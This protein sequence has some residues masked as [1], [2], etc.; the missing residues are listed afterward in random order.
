MR[1]ILG[2][3]F[4]RWV[5]A[6]LGFLCFALLVWFIGPLVAIAEYRPLGPAW[7]RLALIF[8]VVFAYLFTVTLE[9][10]RAR[11]AS[12][13]LEAGMLAPAQTV[14]PGT[15]AATEHTQ[16]QQ[17]FSEALQVL[18][19][20]RSKSA[21]KGWRG[22]MAGLD[23]SRYL[24]ELPWYVIVGAPGTGK[25][26]ALVNS[27]LHFPLAERFGSESVQG[28][29]GTRNC[30]WLFTD[31][32]VL[33]DTAGRYSTQASDKQADSKEWASFLQ[34]LA[35]NRPRQPINGVMVT[36]SATDLI[37]ATTTELD[38][39]ANALRNRIQ[40]LHKELKISFPIYLLVT[41]SDVLSGFAEFFDEMTA[42][43]RA[44][45][46]GVSFP[47]AKEGA[48]P[49]GMHTVFPVEFDSLLDR[50][51]QRVLDLLEKERD[52]ERRS[53]LYSFPQN[54][55][56]MGG[57]LTEFLRLVFAP[58]P[59]EQP[60]MLRGVY[61]T[62]G[63]QDGAQ[64]DPLF[65]QF[66]RPL[67]LDRP[68]PVQRKA[69]GRSYF[70]SRLLT[71]VIFAESQLA[72][73]NRRWLRRRNLI[74]GGGYAAFALV[75]VG[76][77]AGWTVSYLRNDG[78]LLDV[79]KQLPAARKKVDGVVTTRAEQLSD[80]LPA[81]EVVRDVASTQEVKQDKAPY[82]M[83]LG[84]YQGDKLHSAADNAYKRLLHEALL[85]RIAFRL[86]EALRNAGDDPE[87]RYEALKAYLMIHDADHFDATAF[88]T[89]VLVDWEARLSRDVTS[90]QRAELALHLD[91]LLANK[92]VTSPVPL[93]EKLVAEAREALL[94]R[95]LA[96]RV[97]GR[98]KRMGIAREVPDFKATEIA[99]PQAMVVLTRTS[100]EPLSKGVSGFYSLRGYYQHFMKEINGVAREMAEEQSWV[101]GVKQQAPASVPAGTTV[102][103]EFD[104]AALKKLN[105]DVRK[106]YL[107]EYANTWEKYVGDIKLV[108][109]GNLQQSVNAARVLS[110]PDS[111]LAALLRGIVKETSLTQIAEADKTVVDKASDT[112]NQKKEA[113]K[114]MIGQG[115]QLTP[116]DTASYRLE[117]IVDDRFEGLRRLVRS[118]QAGQ[119]APLDASLGL[120]NEFYTYLTATDTAVKSGVPAPQSDLPTRLKAESARMPEPMRSV[121]QSLSTA[122]VSQALG[123]T[124]DNLSSSMS[125]AVADF[126][127][128]A[129]G[130]RYPFN[131]HASS[132]VRQDDFARLFATGGVLDEFFQKNLAQ[133]VDTGKKPWQFRQV[134]EGSMGNASGALIQFQR[135]A[136]IRDVF[137]QGGARTP[138]L[139]LDFK[140]V[141]M[142]A[143]LIQ[144]V[145]DIDGQVIK[146]AHGPQVPTTISWPGP[147]GSGQVRVQF[148]GQGGAEAGGM[149]F[150]GAW[151]LF[152]ALDKAQIVSTNQPEKFR[153]IFDINGKKAQYEVT[154]GSVQNPF[155][156]SELAQ[157][158]CPSRL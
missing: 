131:R 56:E 51:N 80:L 107:E 29:G 94:R 20:A 93:D 118:P 6:A 103:T 78:Y 89:W 130:G 25:T 8:G 5:L 14:E 43:E 133:Y 63:T 48:E 95:T 76:A 10:W 154:S 111:P 122:G 46:W 104:P 90:Q 74:M 136:V 49:V 139:K 23:S 115:D 18:K 11:R 26:T 30:N 47:L 12:K 79:E 143:S 35:K 13:S 148:V 92:S 4:N 127:S 86:E 137:F 128:K 58:S 50:L 60:V 152:R 98:L 1:S 66:A 145:I 64:V 16:L 113:L 39:Q 132:D 32:A 96:E 27:G 15:A 146:Y 17:R 44:Q 62:S 41:K 69:S 70:I 59:Y 61:F 116:A 156:L 75:S 67:A 57:P 87:L 83:R 99:G 126:C 155:R 135:A 54:F 119:P 19:L 157:F 81:L 153:V 82:S 120:L 2:L 52:A 38:L 147:K 68:A 125:S 134:G 40:E 124:R 114:R 36:I 129:V 100:G 117:R 142:D 149:V 109:F 144:S 37:H 3:I 97:Y 138:T 108:Q 53:R 110:A 101:L 151:A 102:P 140:P 84:L 85:P 42:E 28:V 121:M 24:Y 88:K 65:G 112:L 150:E 31:N 21:G 77:L 9:F 34:L 7:I 141:E 73:T 105:E 22:A 72:G 71:D 45:V 106:L 123:V 33:L 91:A 158:Q 55:A